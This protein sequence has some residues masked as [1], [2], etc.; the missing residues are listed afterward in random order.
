LQISCRNRQ[1]RTA[2]HWPRPAAQARL[3][4]LRFGEEGEPAAEGLLVV[5][6]VE[7]EKVGSAI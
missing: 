3:E 7:A 4:V 2:P 5:I 6:V 1:K